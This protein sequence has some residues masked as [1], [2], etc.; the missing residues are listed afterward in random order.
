[1][2]QPP[3]EMGWMADSFTS[4]AIDLSDVN[5]FEEAVIEKARELSRQFYCAAFA[6]LQEKWLE[7]NAGEYTPER[8]RSIRQITPLGELELPVRVVRRR[9]SN[10]GGYLSLSKVLLGAKAT[11]LLSPAVEKCAVMRATHLNYRPAAASF[12]ED[13]ESVRFGH[14]LVWK[15]VQVHG[16]RLAQQLQRGLQP[17]TRVCTDRESERVVTEL[18][19]GWIKRQCRGRDNETRS[20]ARGFWM[21]LSVNYT[22]RQRRWEKR[23]SREVELSDKSLYP[24]VSPMA[25]FGPMARR[26]RDHHYGFDAQGVILSDGDEGLERLREKHF[27]GEPWVLDRWHIDKRLKLVAGENGEALRR[28]RR[29][30]Y[31]ADSEG[32]LEELAACEGQAEC[33]HFTEAF[34]YVLGNREGIDAWNE[35]PRKLR[36]TRGRREAAIKFGTGG[37]EKNIEV[38]LN[39]R[40]KGQ[41]RS[42]NPKRAGYLAG[43]RW[44]YRSKASFHRWWKANVLQKTL[45][46]RTQPQPP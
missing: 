45:N 37:I 46:Q 39:R 5:A 13:N 44:L 32:L 35:I 15:C 4:L 20:P 17:E 40:F 16:R 8:W 22:G 9:G 30:L 14:G 1:M 12:T 28:M 6:W 43:L 33:K 21:H 23:G 24:S 3:L 11:R 38:F 34:G 2:N 7:E 10:R 27:P 25:Q 42:W 26:H 19:S 29:A 41:G 31:R 18:D 36:T